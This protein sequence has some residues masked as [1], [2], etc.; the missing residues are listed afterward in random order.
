MV[1]KN[2]P[3]SWSSNIEA[4]SCKQ[5]AKKKLSKPEDDN[6]LHSDLQ[7][8]RYSYLLIHNI[9]K[10]NSINIIKSDIFIDF[11]SSQFY[12]EHC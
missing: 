6:N 10:T 4:F 1:T 11:L 9:S 12:T 7:F 2:L 3:F 8:F 5:N